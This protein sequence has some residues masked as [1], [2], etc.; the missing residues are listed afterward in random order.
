MSEEPAAPLRI[1]ITP[2]RPELPSAVNSGFDDIGN[3]YRLRRQDEA[4]KADPTSQ[5]LRNQGLDPGLVLE[6]R[7]TYD[8]VE[9]EVYRDGEGALHRRLT[10][11]PVGATTGETMSD[12]VLDRDDIEIGTRNLYR[13]DDY[14]YTP[15]GGRIPAEEANTLFERI[16][17]AVTSVGA[18]IVQE[19]AENP[20]DIAT[21]IV[22]GL[23]DGSMNVLRALRLDGAYTAIEELLYGGTADEATRN[24]ELPQAET[25]V[26]QVAGG[27]A[28]FGPQ[29]MVGGMAVAPVKAAIP[30]M[31]WLKGMGAGFLADMLGD[32]EDETLGD[33]AAQLDAFDNETAEAVRQAFI[34]SLSVDA[35]DGEFERRL[36]QAGGGLIAGAVFDGLLGS[37]K[38]M[39]AIARKTPEVLDDAFGRFGMQLSSVD[40]KTA[41][42]RARQGGATPAVPGADKTI[43]TRLP[44]TK[45]A[46]EDPIAEKLLI[47]LDAMKEKP[48]AFV[49]NMKVIKKYPGFKTA[50]RNPDK[51]A[52]EYVSHVMDNLRFL[53]NQVPAEIR[54]RSRLWYD[55]ARAIT[56]RWSQ[57]YGID[58]D[59]VAGVL[60]ALSP[61]KDWYQNVSLAERVL[62]IHTRFINDP[63]FTMTD[64]MIETAERIY[65]GEKYQALREGI[66]G[67]AY[68]ELDGD[69]QAAWLRAYDQTYN[70]RGYRTVTSEG[71]FIGDPGGNVAWGSL[72]E[73]GKAIDMLKNPTRE[74]A[75]LAMGVK[76]K[77]RNFFN[78]IVSP[79]DPDG[80]VTIDTH[81]VAASMLRPLSGNSPEVHHNFGSSP[82]LA[83]QPKGWQAMKNINNNGA[84]GSYGLYVEAH[85]RLA[86]E[87]GI[88]P[89][90]LQSITWEAVRG[91]FPAKW[92]TAKNAAAVDEIWRRVEKGEIDADAARNEILGL[93]G[94]IEPPTW[95]NGRSDSVDEEVFD[96][97]YAGELAQP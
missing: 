83:K 19:T 25:T 17:E 58:E 9:E 11:Y 86:N 80:H 38:A 36:K 7:P 73:V 21:G 14:E 1:E 72:V 56:E 84:Q 32:P 45:G 90:E 43:S 30:V 94:G 64:E 22:A 77:V 27:F 76:H 78:N 31:G 40:P 48:D 16:R 49:H 91:L 18:Q 3:T 28:E 71:Q 85:R 82:A 41:R 57:K 33:L 70:A 52:E 24:A 55:G 61:Q 12:T 42:Q 2:P 46:T 87:L 5:M 62:D 97:S 96:T 8:R 79:N 23:D 29:L 63:S 44:T 37:Y 53:Y 34:E 10:G 66:S 81:A 13:L 47:G 50:S 35:D 75:T 95:W 15:V 51:I 39:R 92:K 65:P 69:E 74:N 26:G 93:A 6:G 88:L 89:R 59:G 4:I 68:S 67:R 54:D 60:A 20:G